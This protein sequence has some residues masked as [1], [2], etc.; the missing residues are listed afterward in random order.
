[1]V[2]HI[3]IDQDMVIGREPGIIYPEDDV[4]VDCPV[5]Q[6]ITVLRIDAPDHLIFQIDMPSEI[7][8]VDDPMRIGA[9]GEGA[10]KQVGLDIGA[11]GLVGDPIIIGAEP[12]VVWS[13]HQHVLPV[14]ASEDISIERGDFPVRAVFEFQRAIIVS[15]ARQ[16]VG[17]D[18]IG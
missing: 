2:V 13:D 12:A 1:M 8:D 18:R 10:D 17:V 4:V 6:N 16:P 9:I 7:V 3:D 14:P 15:N 11:I 5:P